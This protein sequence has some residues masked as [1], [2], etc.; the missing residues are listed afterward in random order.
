MN[1]INLITTV[2]LIDSIGLSLVALNPQQVISEEIF[3]ETIHQFVS[4]C[5]N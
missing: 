3:L 4:V 2:V 5:L 1:R